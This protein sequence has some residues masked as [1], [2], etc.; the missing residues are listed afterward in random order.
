M[1]HA[2]ITRTSTPTKLLGIWRSNVG[3]RNDHRNP[4]NH[5]PA[6]HEGCSMRPS[7]DSVEVIESKL[8]SMLRFDPETGGMYRQH[9][10]PRPN[11]KDPIGCLQQN[12]YLYITF[13]GHHFICHRLAWFLHF[14]AW[15]NNIIDHINGIKTDNRISNL[16]DVSNSENSQNKR[17][18][19]NGKT[20][21]VA[22]HRPGV[23]RVFLPKFFNGKTRPDSQKKHLGLYP[24]KQEA[25]NA[26]V[27]YF[28]NLK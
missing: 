13:F 16:R 8:R 28:E 1:R 25:E 4:T 17:C 27:E 18:H 11:K 12:G 24:T 19:R 23:W 14:G 3:T 21:G 26:L 7:T 6:V 10:H 9:P 5:H 22:L 15:P 20:M 2:P